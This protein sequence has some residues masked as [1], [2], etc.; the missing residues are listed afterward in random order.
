MNKRTNGQNDKRTNGQM[1][2]RTN[3]QMNKMTKGQTNK[4][5]NGQTRLILLYEDARTHVKKGEPENAVGKRGKAKPA[6]VHPQS[7]GILLSFS[8]FCGC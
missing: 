3:G 2:K 1:D 7:N 8:P 5:T 4:Q 6:P